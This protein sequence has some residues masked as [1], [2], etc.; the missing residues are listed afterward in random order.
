MFISRLILTL[1][2]TSLPLSCFA[3]ERSAYPPTRKLT[4]EQSAL[5]D[6]AI[7]REKILIKVI[8]QRTPL[9]ETY[10]Q[11]NRADDK[12][13]EVPVADHYMLSRVN[14]GKG[15]FDRTYEAKSAGKHARI[16]GSLQSIANLSKWLGLDTSL[17]YNP[18][19]FTEMMFL[20][21][22]G[23]DRE[24]YEFSF[25]RKEFLGSVRTWVFDVHPKSSGAGRFSG[26]IW[27]E[28]QDGN[29]VRLNGTFTPSKSL[30]SP[31]LF[32][33]FDSWRVNVQPGVWLPAAVYVEE[34][35][36]SERDTAIGLRAQTHFWGYSLRLPTRDSENVSMRVDDA[37]DKSDDSQDVGPL[38]AERQWVAQA[39]NNVLDR[40]VQAGLLAPANPDGFERKVLDQIVVNL[41][42]PSNLAFTTPVHCRLLL[43][44][45][46]EATTVG[47]TILLTKGL[48]DSLP[49]E[50]AIASVIALELA[51]VELGHHIDTRYAFNDRLLFPDEASFQRI[52]MSHKEGEDEAA[53]K[54]AQEYLLASMYKD[55]L[56]TAALF[57]TQLA[58][59]GKALKELNTPK[60]GDSLLR[61][62]GSPWMTALAKSAPKL[63]WDN[64]NQIPALPLG[65][66][67]KTDPWDD[68]VEMVNAT[69][70]APLNAREKLPLEVTPVFYRLH[71]RSETAPQQALDSPGAEGAEPASPR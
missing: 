40:L 31:K 7:A 16:K 60:L 35:Q 43:M 36:R 29:I 27:I 38:E 62:D 64:L 39:E 1:L 9:V 49:N 65:S 20:D 44:T 56:A 6:K 71:R 47:N 18:L 34:T 32:F 50:E 53:A 24:H 55:K 70:S 15:F 22:Y 21:P 28:D 45:T 17:T 30:D 48:I 57:W 54:R 41:S 23:A 68:H 12:L 61:A 2:L 59:R 67:L 69:R 14:F 3:K 66:W 11:D 37:E 42:V 51:H 5:V 63:D 8:Q 26:R 46:V 33:H 58:D 13:R 19:G 10:I 25:A 52:D 4:P